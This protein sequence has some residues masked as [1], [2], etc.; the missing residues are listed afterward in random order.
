MTPLH[1]TSAASNRTQETRTWFIFCPFSAG[2]IET[3]PRNGAWFIFRPD[4]ESV[5]HVQRT[6]AAGVT[7]HVVA[8][9]RCK[10]GR[11]LKRDLVY[12]LSVRNKGRALDRAPSRQ[13][14][15]ATPVGRDGASAVDGPLVRVPP[16]MAAARAA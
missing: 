16:W 12:F 2:A 6:A 10:N 15:R 8:P 3:V 14:P 13:T 9:L 1:R 7:R 11:P 5:G 4:Q